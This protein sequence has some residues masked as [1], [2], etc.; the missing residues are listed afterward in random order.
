MKRSTLSVVIAFLLAMSATVVSGGPMM[1]L[2]PDDGTPHP[3]PAQSAASPLLDALALVPLG[4]STFEFTD[5]R[6]LKVLHGG[7]DIT[8]ASP[9]DE[10]QRLMLDIARSE[11]T[12]FRLG[13]DRLATWPELWGWDTTDLAWQASCCNAPDFA[14]LRFRDDWDPQPFMA[15]L[16]EYGY[17]RSDKPHATSFTFGPDTDAPSDAPLERAFAVEYGGG[18][19]N[20]PPEHRASAAISTDGHTVVIVRGPDAHRIL[21]M[22][23]RIDPAAVVESP[24]GRVAVALGRP[25]AADIQETGQGCPWAGVEGVDF[26]EEMLALARSLG[27]FHPYEALGIGYERAGPGEPAVGRYV[28]AYDKAKHAKADLPGR[29]TLIDEG[30]STLHGAPYRDR[31]FTLIDAVADGRELIL[32]VALVDDTPQTLFDLPIARSLSFAKCE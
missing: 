15:R 14:L 10:R 23:A 31:A 11:T 2:S 8:S 27:P 26:T 6:A 5:W 32:D 4:V 12:T 30:Y 24:F 20:L 16:E 22:A 28:F 29:R 1:A 25:L 21:K 9:L 18:V 19:G 13:L 7:A 3:S 17:V